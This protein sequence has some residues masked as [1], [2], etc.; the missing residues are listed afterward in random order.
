MTSFRGVL[1]VAFTFCFIFDAS[2]FPE[3]GKWVFDITEGIQLLG[4]TKSMFAD[5]KI[6]VKSKFC[7]SFLLWHVDL[8]FL[9]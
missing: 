4:V 8:M 1:L 2:A 5:S 3:K 9:Y 6:F 7:T